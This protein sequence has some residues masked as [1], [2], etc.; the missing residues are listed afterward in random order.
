MSKREL[1]WG[2]QCGGKGGSCQQDGQCVDAPWQGCKCPTGSQCVRRNEWHWQCDPLPAPISSGGSSGSSE[3]LSK[4]P[5]IIPK[6][7]ATAKLALKWQ[8]DF[9]SNVSVDTSKWEYH[10]GD[11]RDYT[12]VQGWG[13][14][15]LQAYTNN[16]ENVNIVNKTL[17]FTAKR[18]GICFNPLSKIT[19][20]ADI[21][22]G[23]L[24]SR[25]PFMYGE[26]PI[27]VTARIQVPMAKGSFPAFWMIPMRGYSSGTGTHGQ[28]CLSGEIDIME[29]VNSEKKVQSTLIYGYPNQDCQFFRGEYQLENPSDWH[30]YTLFWSRNEIKTYVDGNLMCQKNI[31]GTPL[32]NPMHIALNLAVGGNWAGSDNPTLPCSMSVDYVMVHDI[33]G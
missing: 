31:E 24:I 16:T 20:N 22:S 8:D 5:F 2:Q 12:G 27:L 1:K 29:H 4:K 33:L 17:V 30:V 11:G 7:M 3:P 13:N 28:W 23:K 9:S 6:D 15:E 32:D 18:G 10:L 25:V 14:K 19:Y 21:T 26:K